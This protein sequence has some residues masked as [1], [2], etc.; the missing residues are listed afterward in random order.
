MFNELLEPEVKESIPETQK[1]C[2]SVSNP[3]SKEVKLRNVVKL[4]P[5]MFIN[6]TKQGPE[7]G[8]ALWVERG[9]TGSSSFA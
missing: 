2:K 5:Y 9:L 6:C 1:T 3:P 4:I 7:V 8:Q